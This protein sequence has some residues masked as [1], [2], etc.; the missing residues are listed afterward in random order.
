MIQ[1]NYDLNVFAGGSRSVRWL[2]LNHMS[3]T[4]GIEVQRQGHFRVILIYFNLAPDCNFL[5]FLLF[6]LSF[7]ESVIVWESPAEGIKTGWMGD[8]FFGYYNPVKLL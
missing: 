3:P 4:R 7:H 1:N 5:V 2:Q 8:K 6:P